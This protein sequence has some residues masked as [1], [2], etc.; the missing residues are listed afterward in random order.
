MAPTARRD[1]THGGKC[2]SINDTADSRVGNL[3]SSFDLTRFSIGHLAC[4]P[5]VGSYAAYSAYMKR[6]H[7]K[8]AG[9]RIKVPLTSRAV[10]HFL[11]CS[12]IQALWW[13]ERPCRVLPGWT[14]W[15]S[16]FAGEGVVAKRARSVV[17]KCSSSGVY[18][19]DSRCVSEQTSAHLALGNHPQ[20]ADCDHH[21]SWDGTVDR[22]TLCGGGAVEVAS[23]EDGQVVG[24]IRCHLRRGTGSLGEYCFGVQVQ[25][26]V[27][28]IRLSFDKRSS[29]LESFPS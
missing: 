9:K 24:R 17:W 26:G 23:G 3:A 16:T 14:G 29:L 18:C 28:F 15:E 13:Y 11:L 6:I 12:I 27:C 5:L 8:V 4:R 22:A 1:R 21:P 20:R 25:R 2:Y 10:Y 7:S 19:C